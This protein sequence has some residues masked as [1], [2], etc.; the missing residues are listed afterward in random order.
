MIPAYGDGALLHEAVRSVLAQDSPTWRLTVIDDGGDP[1]AA[2]PHPGGAL[3]TDDEE[4]SGAAPRIEEYLAGLGDG[5]VRYLRNP[6]TLGINRNFQ[7]CLDEAGADLVVVLGS[8][9][10]LLPDYVRTVVEVAE[11]FPAAAWIHPAVR[12]ID[13]S[14]RPTLPL[15][16]RIKALMRPRVHGA[17]VLGGQ[18]LTSSLLQGNWMYFPQ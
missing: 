12:V 7:R 2:G 13:G 5:R 17:R 16:D 6:R 14:G 10:R 3:H 1:R 9:D 8:D 18:R 4:R 11:R 15:A